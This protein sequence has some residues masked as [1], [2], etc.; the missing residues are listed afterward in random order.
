M[1]ER[2]GAQTRQSRRRRLLG[3]LAVALHRATLASLGAVAGRRGR[4]PQPDPV[5][6]LL[7]HAWGMGGTIRTTLNLARALSATHDVQVVSVLRRRAEPFFPLPAGVPVT[8]IDDRV[9][10]GRLARVLGRAPSLLIHP[11]DYAY[12]WCSLWSDVLLF[13]ALRRMRGGVLICT[14]PAL[15]LVAARLAH[16]A[17][18]DPWH[19]RGSWCRAE[20][21][22]WGSGGSYC[23][24]RGGWGSSG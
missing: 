11:E 14:R 1:S 24:R 6:F 5:R 15:N 19:G 4:R 8:A 23:E 3:P 17:A 21:R 12:P 18:P 7:A 16:P 22:G 2:R 13:R 9:T 20:S 10:A